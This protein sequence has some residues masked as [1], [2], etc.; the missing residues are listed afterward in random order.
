MKTLLLLLLAASLLS[1]C[2]TR[3]NEEADQRQCEQNLRAIATAASL[4][5]RRFRLD[6]YLKTF[7]ICPA[8]GYD[9]YSS[10]YQAVKYPDAF[11]ISCGGLHHGSIRLVYSAQDGLTRKPVQLR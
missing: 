7:P 6:G 9:T 4:N 8:A 2:L 3:R 1:L 5:Y 11:T 10:S